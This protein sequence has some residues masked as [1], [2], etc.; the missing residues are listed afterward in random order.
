M[1][2]FLTGE[3]AGVLGMDNYSV[4]TFNS[5]QHSGYG[6]SSAQRNVRRLFRQLNG[7]NCRSSMHN[8]VHFNALHVRIQRS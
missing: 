4:F 7:S 6:N 1:I 8:L 3:P 2:P 5:A